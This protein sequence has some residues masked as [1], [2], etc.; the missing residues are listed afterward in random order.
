MSGVGT[1]STVV[2]G[3]EEIVTACILF[4]LQKKCMIEKQ[5]STCPLT[6]K[7]LCTI[8][9]HIFVSGAFVFLNTKFM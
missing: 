3:D 9:G 1:L 8:F 2:R 7:L 6:E 5:Q 4:V